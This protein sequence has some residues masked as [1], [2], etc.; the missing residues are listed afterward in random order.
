MSSSSQDVTARVGMIGGI[1]LF[2]VIWM[3][4]TPA[5]MSPEAQR[6]LAIT[7]T[8]SAFWLTQ[9]IPIGATSLIP[10]IMFPL[11]GIQRPDDVSNAYINKMTFLFLGGFII[12][13]GIE[14]W[15]LHQR[16]ALHIVKLL[17]TSLR[18]VILGFM[19]A[20]AFL[21]MW[22]S[23]T[24]STLLMTPIA[25]ALVVSLQDAIGGSSIRD[26]KELEATHGVDRNG[27]LGPFGISLMLGI[28][29]AA[30]IGGLT[31]LVGTITNVQFVG[32]WEAA[33][34]E[35]PEI[36]AGKWLTTF[37]PVGF[38]LILLAWGMLVF[39]M[40]T[41]GKGIERS[42][43][44]ER[45]KA[46]GKPSQAEWTMLAVFA[47]TA[48]LWT[49]RKPLQFG[50]EPLLPGW[51]SAVSWFLQTKLGASPE[52]AKGAVHD[53][54]VAIGM[55]ILMFMLPSGKREDGRSLRIMDWDTAVKLP[56]QILLLVGGGFAIAGAFEQTGLAEWV[57]DA[58]AATVGNW[59]TWAVIMAVCLMLTFLT[60]FATN[61]VVVSVILPVLA[62]A[63]LRLNVDPRL[64]M[65]PAAASASCAFML[66]I[67]TP[68]N[69]IVFSSGILT[70]GDMARKGF[71]LNLIG[72]LLMTIATVFYLVPAFGI[73]TDG[74]PEW[75]Q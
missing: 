26:P 61:V 12:A 57:G 69:A 36:S 1:V 32:L 68:P 14:R 8:M 63:S 7:A 25:I 67:G 2:F 18:R 45:L 52:F 17:G 59:Q 28:A 51:S 24:A 13:L 48:L 4:P 22:I 6:L 55:S 16:M 54:S 31:T 56:W 44:S 30:S 58:F 53:S 29:W 21:S 33:F 47:A 34:P 42:F 37:A 35:G 64:L 49:F 43:F 75:A 71:L 38:A 19:F 74:L 73:S 46:L 23:N 40:P 5:G 39:R 10:I 72:V 66:P 65:L 11:L 70:M 15:G 9:A 27:P 3:M 50:S 41:P 62:E 60:E 20:T